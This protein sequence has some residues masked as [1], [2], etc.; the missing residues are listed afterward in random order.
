LYRGI[1]TFKKGYQP[2]INIVNDVKGDFVTDYH[3]SQLL[4]LHGICDVK[5]TEVHIAKALVLENGSFEV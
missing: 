3:F 4:N 5:Q 2:R 1:S